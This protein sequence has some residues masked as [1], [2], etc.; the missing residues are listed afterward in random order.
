MIPLNHM[1]AS[2]SA[3]A[4]EYT[5]TDGTSP[6]S[7]W[8]NA[9]DATTAIKI[10]TAVTRMENGNYSNSKP[11]GDGVH[12]CKIDFG[13]GFRVYFAMDGNI[14]IILLLGG[15]KRTQKK[16]IL[17]AKEY[18]LDYKKRKIER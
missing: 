11:V 7:E 12:E 13:P 15:S 9:L 10:T 18:W 16:D 1:K 8:F 17:R 14:L 2:I 3:P 6:F 4:I 5:R